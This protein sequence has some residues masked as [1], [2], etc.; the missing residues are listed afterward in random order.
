MELQIQDLVSSIRKEG[1]D[2]ANA[3]AQEILADA[4]KKA[5]TIISQARTEAKNTKDSAER[6]IAILKESAAMSAEQAKR[7]AVLAFK[8]EIQ[9]EFEKILSADVKSATTEDVL[10]GLIKAAVQGEDLSG[11]A[12]EVANVSDSLKAKLAEE[13]RGGLTIRPTKNVQAGFRLAAK[14]GSGY[15]DCSDEEI[16]QMLMPYFRNLSF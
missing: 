6:E 16:T 12:A 11:Y 5:D 2:A 13:I 14:D 15:F 1:I 10:A 9:K 4:Q 7:D 8:D 3:Q